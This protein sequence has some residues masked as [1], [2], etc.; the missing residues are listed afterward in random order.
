M[1]IHCFRPPALD[2]TEFALFESL[3]RRRF[4]IGAGAL[5]LAGCGAPGGSA[6][7]P[8]APALRQLTDALGEVVSVPTPPQRIVSVWGY[9]SAAILEAGGSVIGGTIA[10]EPLL[11]QDLRATFDLSTFTDIGGET[12]QPNI[13]RIAALN[14]DLIITATQGGTPLSADVL[15]QLRAIAPVFAIEVFQS[16]EALSELMIALLGS[17]AEALIATERAAFE[18]QLAEL[19]ALLAVEG[20][21]TAFALHFAP[22]GVYTYGPTELPAVDV[23]TRAGARWL[24]IV[25][26]AVANGGDLQLSLERIPELSADL[27]V[28]YNLGT[29]DFAALPV[30]AALP[31]NRVGQ[32]I[33]LPETHQAITWRNYARIARQYS[34]LLQPLAP[35][36]ATVVAEAAS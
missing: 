17:Q 10:V 19:R 3:T 23:L 31:A 26:E 32:L 15:P 16:V 24:P 9:G 12:G 33:A 18:Q 2:E 21:S 25:D 4:L 7:V 27:V 30:A 13:E 22:D 8:S 29:A 6:P 34:D 20:L 5:V 36:D 1:P 11:E 14:P 28:A 35:L